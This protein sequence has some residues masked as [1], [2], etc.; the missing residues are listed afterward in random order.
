MSP[1][2]AYLEAQAVSCVVGGATLL[3]SA[4]VRFQARPVCRHPGA[5]WRR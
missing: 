4:S 1:H 5:E 3:Q 2:S